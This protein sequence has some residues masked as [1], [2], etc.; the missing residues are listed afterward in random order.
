MRWEEVCKPKKIGG[1][2]LRSMENH[3]KVLLQKKKAWR[4]LTQNDS[5]WVQCLKAK[6]KIVDDVFDFLNEAGGKKITWSSSWKGLSQALLEL[7]KGLKKRV[8]NGTYTRFWVDQWLDIPL[9]EDIYPLPSFSQPN[10]M[11][12]EFIQSPGV[13][14]DELLFSQLPLDLAVQVFGYPLPKVTGME[15][16][17]VWGSSPDGKFNTR[18]A[19]LNILNETC[20]VENSCEY[21]WIWKLP[22]TARWILFLWLVWRERLVTNALRFSRGLSSVSSCSQCG[23]LVEDTLHALRDCKEARAIW[24]E[25]IPWSKH[26]SFFG[27][28][29]SEWL[30][31]GLDLKTKSAWDVIIFSTALWRI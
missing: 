28:M 7:S 27:K 1:L 25:L 3:N 29:L 20:D 2:G 8:G 14:N 22:V 15:D 23:C 17:Y 19:Y 10:V 31:T 26:I 4:F 5:L 9:H 30:T 13:W 21:A 18:S 16:R 24:E 6:Y 11:V 12:S